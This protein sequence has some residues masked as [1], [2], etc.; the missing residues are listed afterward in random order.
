[1]IIYREVMEIF[2]CRSLHNVQK[3][4]KIQNMQEKKIV[5]LFF[6]VLKGEIKREMEYL[7]LLSALR[8]F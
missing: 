4:S 3:Y 7:K 8:I 5:F 1:M 2:V 6:M